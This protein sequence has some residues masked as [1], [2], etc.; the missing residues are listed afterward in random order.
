V[1][2]RRALVATEIQE[3][4]RALGIE[5]CVSTPEQMRERTAYEIAKWRDIIEKAHI[6]KE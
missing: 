1:S 3:K 4:S 2:I 6:A 5:A